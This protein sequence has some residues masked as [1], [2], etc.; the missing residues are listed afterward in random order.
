MSREIRIRLY[1]LTALAALTLAA[2]TGRD[3]SRSL[4]LV[5]RNDGPNEF[6]LVPAK[7][8]QQPEDLTALPEPTP[9]G[10]NRSDRNPEAEAIAALGGD[11]GAIFGPS[12]AA[13]NALLA[14]ATRFG[15]DS[16]I[17][18]ELARDHLDYI[19][20]PRGILRRRISL[21][22]EEYLDAYDF[23]ALD[24]A[25]MNHLARRVGTRTPA[26]QPLSISEAAVLAPPPAE[27]EPGQRPNPPTETDR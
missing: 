17:R 2:C 7:P 4:T 26:V 3:G 16:D 15:V 1:A 27:Q 11:Q 20:Q 12:P 22:P 19:R 5:G 9:G 18:R 6:S 10:P 23:M 8:L 21:T 13:D 25:T 24:Q 14:N